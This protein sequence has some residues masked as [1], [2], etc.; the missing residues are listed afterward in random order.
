ML[1]PVSGVLTVLSIHSI[2]D[3][4]EYHR[5][6]YWEGDIFW[7]K[8]E[9]KIRK[10]NLLTPIAKMRMWTITFLHL[11]ILASTKWK[12]I[13]LIINFFAATIH[14]WVYLLQETEPKYSNFSLRY[15]YIK[16]RGH[17]SETLGIGK[18]FIT[19]SSVSI[20]TLTYENTYVLF[21]IQININTYQSE[22]NESH[23]SYWFME[24]INYNPK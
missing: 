3:I 10:N 20:S 8:N 24:I 13:K 12:L 4:I 19:S 21:K 7:R 1:R 18:T 14:K 23:I 16:N 17:F 22:C 9:F 5:Y 11:P 15:K 2:I 6:E